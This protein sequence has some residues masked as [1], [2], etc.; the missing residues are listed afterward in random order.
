M[1]SQNKEAN[2]VR[3]DVEVI[4]LMGSAIILE[5]SNTEDVTDHDLP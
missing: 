4:E 5:G 1:S 2:Y 3:P